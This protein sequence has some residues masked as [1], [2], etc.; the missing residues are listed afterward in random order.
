MHAGPTLPRQTLC[1]L[2][3][4]KPINIS[5]VN[6]DANGCSQIPLTELGLLLKEQA[7]LGSAA[8]RKTEFFT[9]F[10][11][12]KGV[13]FSKITLSSSWQQNAFEKYTT[14]LC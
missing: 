8:G 14:E 1:S 12:T 7:L 9:W 5:G 6:I 11:T 4:E 2:A 13:Y 3:S 10:S